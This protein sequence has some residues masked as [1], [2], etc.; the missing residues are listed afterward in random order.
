MKYTVYV[1]LLLVL[2]AC[3]SKPK[4]P[5]VSKVQ[6]S[7]Q[8]IRF[9]NDFFA[10]DTLHI[11]ASLQAVY[12]K[13]P[14][15]TQDFLFNILGVSPDSARDIKLFLRSYRD[16]YADSRKLFGDFAPIAAEIRKGM[17]FVK[18]YFPEYKLPVRLITFI[19]PV[20]SYGNII[21]A[22]A[23]AIGLQL[24]MGRDYPLYQ[25]AMSQE[26]YPP[27]IARKFEPA[28]IP[29]NCMKNII[30]DMFPNKVTGPLVEQMVEAGKRQYLLN[31]LLPETADTLK[32]GYTAKQLSGCYD[33][34]KNIWSFFV[35]SDLLFS[36][37]PNMTRDYM[38]DAPNTQALGPDSP[39]NIGQFVGT[40]I[41]GK[42]MQK[43]KEVP[44]TALMQTPAKR[45][46]D[47]AK[48]KP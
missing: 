26:L 27:F 42:W 47:E 46:F 43:N 22:D 24:Y 13:Y 20:N 28:Y 15:F 44:L 35:Q 38:N 33:N 29:V 3:S 11:D 19:G 12:Q 25:T 16:M 36:I 2:S 39:G 34:E 7:S 41:V 31:R 32:T 18:Y 21:T 9:E 14:G 37:D 23:L 45:I 10:V 40:Q 48:Y 6:V 8:T 4:T 1:C 17:Q 5:D 30:D